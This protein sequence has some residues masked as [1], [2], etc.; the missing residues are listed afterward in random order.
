MAFGEVPGSRQRAGARQEQLDP[1]LGRRV[2]GDEPQCAL[3]PPCGAR[4]RTV[5]SRLARLA[6]RRDR[7]GIAVPRRAARRGERAPPP[8][9]RE[10]P[11][12][13]RTARARPAATRPASTRRRPAGRA[14]AGS[15][16]AAA[17]RSDGRGRVAAARRAPSMRG[18][19]LVAAAAAASSGSNGSPATA[20]PSSTRRASSVSSAELLG[21]RGGH[22]RGHLEP[23]ERQLR[24][25]LPRSW[26]CRSSDRASCS[27]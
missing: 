10:P 13:R 11:A 6:E 8:E 19:L 22:S 17:P 3:E 5:G 7:D 21:Q 20:A 14:G 1:L 2:V 18:G 12:P 23:G 15:G 16:S 25:G 26:A 24:A 4:G 9:R 27:R